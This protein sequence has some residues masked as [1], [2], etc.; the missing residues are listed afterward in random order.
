MAISEAFYLLMRKS[1]YKVLEMGKGRM[2]LRVSSGV[3]VEIL[4]R[5]AGMGLTRLKLQPLFQESLTLP[6]CANSISYSVPNQLASARIKS[7]WPLRICL[8]TKMA[9]G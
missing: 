9:S 5:M 7:T 1:S 2:G 4:A 6:S 8:A 3:R